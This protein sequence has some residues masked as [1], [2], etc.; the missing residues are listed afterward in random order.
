MCNFPWLSRRRTSV[1]VALLSFLWRLTISTYDTFFSGDYF[2]LLEQGKALDALFGFF[3]AGVNH[4]RPLELRFQPTVVCQPPPI[5]DATPPA[6]F[7][8]RPL[9]PVI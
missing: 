1:H 4:D 7:F 9:S 6:S 5:S 8:P 2:A 3:F